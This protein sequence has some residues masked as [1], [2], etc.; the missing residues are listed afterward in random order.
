MSI[1]NWVDSED[2]RRRVREWA[3]G[4]AMVA[5][6]ASFGRPEQA[7]LLRE[8]NAAGFGAAH[9]SRDWGGAGLGIEQQVILY[10]ELAAAAVP[11]LP[12]YFVA[13]NHVYATLTAWGTTDQC[14]RFLPEIL[15]GNHVWCQGFSE[16]EAGSDL[17]AVRTRAVIRGDEYVV[18]G[19]KIWSSRADLADWCLLLVRTEVDAPKHAALSLL[20]LELDQPGVDVRPIRQATGEAEFCEIFL[21]DAVVPRDLLVGAQGE[22]WKV[23][24]TTLGAE[25]GPTLLDLSARLGQALESVEGLAVR[26][27][28]TGPDEIT[29]ERI[30]RLRCRVRAVQLLC[31]SVVDEMARDADTSASAAVI[32]IAFSELQQD[33]MDLGVDLAGFDGQLIDRPW[34]KDFVGSWAWLIGGG[35]ND[36]LRNVVAQRVLGMPRARLVEG[37]T[38]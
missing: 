38:R 8:L 4:L 36:I 3:S 33:I 16:P 9:W 30:A 37:V 6:G 21:T 35:T 23:C 14:R 31:R 22:G 34:L 27:S 12:L 10:E 29:C 7:A 15:E 2:F 26:R 5:S 13:L 25:R 24:Q 32:K 11:E 28:P 18:N 19:Q 17:A 20:L 1:L